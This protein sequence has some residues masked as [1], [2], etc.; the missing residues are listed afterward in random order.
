MQVKL[1]IGFVSGDERSF[2]WRLTM[3][4]NLYFFAALYNLTPPETKQKVEELASFLEI[5][6]QLEQVFQECSTGT[7]QRM[8]ILRSLLHNPDVLFMDEPTKSLDHLAGR[9]LLSFIKERLSREQ[10]KTVFFTTHNLSET[11]EI[12]DRIAIMRKGEITAVGTIEE[13]RRLANKPAGKHE[14][15]YEYFTR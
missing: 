12:S 3:R 8:A 10:G 14:E 11:A 4:Q 6:P 5:T 1:R 7:K 9:H 15:L 2:Y 13:L